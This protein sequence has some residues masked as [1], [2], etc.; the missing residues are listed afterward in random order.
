MTT[1]TNYTTDE[2]TLLTKGPGYV[3]AYVMFA[4][5]HIFNLEEERPILFEHATDRPIPLAAQELI[6]SLIPYIERMKE[7]TQHLPGYHDVK[8]K[9]SDQMKEEILVGIHEMIAILEAKATP[10][11]A[12][13]FKKWLMS[14]AQMV[15]EAANEDE[16]GIGG[17]RV[18]NKEKTVLTELS[19]T[20]GL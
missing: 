15:A 20:L 7:D 9:T 10:E 1:S 8:G 3:G 19:S 17:P 5:F 13:G 11:E 12:L 4:D 16:M 6:E 2:W 14:I 18:S